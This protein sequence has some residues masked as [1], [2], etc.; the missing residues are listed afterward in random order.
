MKYFLR[1]LGLLAF[2]LFVSVSLNFFLPRMMPGDPA[3]ALLDKMENLQPEQLDTIRAAFGLDTDD[4]VIVQY[5]RYLRNTLRGDLGTSFSRF[6][7]PVSEVMRVALPWSIGLMGLCTII[8]FSLGTLIGIAA[9]WRRETKLAS[10]TVGFFSFVRSFPYFW[11]GLVFIYFFAFK[12][13]AFPIGGAYSVDAARGGAAWWLSVLRHGA[14]P[15]AT[16]VVSSLGAWILTMRNNMINVLAEDYITVA[17]AKGLPIGRIKSMY[18]AKN[19]ILP[20]VTGFAMSL[21]F[22]IGGGLVTEMVFAY[23]GIGYMLYQAVNA[24][25]YPLMQAIFLFIAVA[26]LIANF[27]ADVAVMIL[28]PRVRD[29]AK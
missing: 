10:A 1:K 9:A 8:S 24:K 7:T 22:V 5:G 6:P 28:D 20:S 18:A 17:M 19:A 3:R 2:T 23:P 21:G 27:A 11:L 25:D 14:L 16:I 26:V 12:L 4:P 15:A 29:G 13:R